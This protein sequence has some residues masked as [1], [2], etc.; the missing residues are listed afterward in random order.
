MAFGHGLGHFGLLR[1]DRLGLL[2]DPLLGRRPRLLELLSGALL[3]PVRA[4]NGLAPIVGVERAMVG[5]TLETVFLD[6]VARPVQRG[7][8]TRR[9]GGTAP[10][11]PLLPAGQAV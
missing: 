10:R 1:L 11:R 7:P 6:L 8:V 3:V 2:A 9:N 5:H 4:D